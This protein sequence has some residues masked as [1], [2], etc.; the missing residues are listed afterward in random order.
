M[1]QR[2]K[3]IQDLLTGQPFLPPCSHKDF[4]GVDV[5]KYWGKRNCNKIQLLLSQT[6]FFP[7][8]YQKMSCMIEPQQSLHH[9]FSF[10]WKNCLEKAKKVKKRS[11]FKGIWQNTM[12]A[13]KWKLL[14][15]FVFPL[16]NCFLLAE[17]QQME[18][19]GSSGHQ[20]ANSVPLLYLYDLKTSSADLTP[21]HKQ[22]LSIDSK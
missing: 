6:H 17:K 12:R 3:D 15:C 10:K 20:A 4:T 14:F 16:L 7:R 22:Q 18:Q 1:N 19:S 9:F 13:N 2:P 11:H 5:C 21:P 8:N